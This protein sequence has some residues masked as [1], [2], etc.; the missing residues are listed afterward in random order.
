MNIR[1]KIKRTTYWEWRFYAQE[2]HNEQLKAD[3]E[4]KKFDCQEKEIEI[5]KL[6]QVLYKGAIKA[7]HD[8]ALG[9][10]HEFEKFI[11]DLELK[12]GFSLKNCAIDDN[13]LEVKELD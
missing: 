7:Q 13:T 3:L 10:K 4:Q 5:A 9:K 2:M 12:L 8:K 1:G 6:K 11:N